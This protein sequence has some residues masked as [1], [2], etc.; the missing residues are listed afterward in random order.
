[1]KVAQQFIAGLVSQEREDFVPKGTQGLS[2]R[3]LTP[4]N[5]S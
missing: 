3:V 5:A 1:M 4:G 2:P